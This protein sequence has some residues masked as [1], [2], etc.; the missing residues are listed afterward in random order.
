MQSFVRHQR[1]SIKMLS[2]VLLCAA[3]M[4]HAGGAPLTEDGFRV[5]SD[6]QALV[7]PRAHGSHPDFRLEWWYVTGHLFAADGRRFGFQTTFFRRARATTDDDKSRTATSVFGLDQIYLAHIALLDV[8]GGRHYAQERLNRAGWDAGADTD[9]LRVWNGNWQMHMV[10][11]DSRHMRLF[12]DMDARTTLSIDLRPMKPKVLFGHDGISLK[13]D[14]PTSRSYYITFSRLH[15]EGYIG[16]DGERVAVQG[17]A[18]MDH[19]ISSGQLAPGQVGWDWTAIQ[20][21]DG[22]EIMAFRLRREDGSADP[23][24]YLAWVDRDGKLS[25][26]LWGDWEWQAS[27]EWQ[28]PHTGAHYPLD[29]TVVTRDPESGELRRL[30]LQPLVQDQEF[31]GPLAGISYW[32]G[33]C[34][35]LD[36]SGQEIGSAYVELTGYTED[37]GGRM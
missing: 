35:V 15:A 12:G 26:A 37:L 8:Q 11:E 13:G 20:L 14:L 28:S 16:I 27:G 22:R 21:D 23:F 7:F 6:P 1:I 31:N 10:D 30:Q 33:A 5:P 25:H 2:L 17:S 36:E 19:E 18:W 29:I 34:R 24:S 4:G 9:T 3:V 32:E